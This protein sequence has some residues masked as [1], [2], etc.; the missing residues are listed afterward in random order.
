MW[1]PLKSCFEVSRMLLDALRCC[2]MLSGAAGA[3]RAV[4]SLPAFQGLK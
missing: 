2:W 3:R 1:S 4:V